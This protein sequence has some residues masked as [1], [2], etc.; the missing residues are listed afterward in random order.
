MKRS[1]NKKITIIFL[2][3][4]LALLAVM[5]MVV[6]VVASTY[7]QS[8][9]NDDVLNRHKSV[10]YELVDMLNEVNYGYTRI[11]KSDKFLIF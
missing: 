11:T 3:V 6:Q 2:S 1:L 7:V 5:L 4:L 10:S 8:Y 9:T